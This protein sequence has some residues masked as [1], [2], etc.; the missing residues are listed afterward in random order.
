MA[1]YQERQAARIE[2]MRPLHTAV[3]LMPYE[4]KIALV[5]ECGWGNKG[6][7][8]NWFDPTSGWNYD[9]HDAVVRILSLTPNAT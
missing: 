3:F 6:D 4:E 9:L 2:E 8:N 1:V 7:W 5:N